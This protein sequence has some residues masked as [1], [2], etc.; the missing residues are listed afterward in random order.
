MDFFDNNN[1]TNVNNQD[2]IQSGNS[3]YNPERWENG[4]NGGQYNRQMPQNPVY[5]M[6]K[7][8]TEKRQETDLLPLLPLS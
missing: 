2:N 6:M 5:Y 3:G 4:Y 1:T 7:R 8:K